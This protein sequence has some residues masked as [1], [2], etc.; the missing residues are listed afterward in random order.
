MGEEF[1]E[2]LEETALNADD[3]T[4]NDG[5]DYSVLTDEFLKKRIEDLWIAA[6]DAP[7][8]KMEA[9]DF[10]EEQIASFDAE[11]YKNRRFNKHRLTT[12]FR[13]ID[14]NL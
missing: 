9:Q 5:I 2:A 14:L 12:D 7:E 13:N 11:E 4:V 8:P 3:G 6:Y 1:E 10:L